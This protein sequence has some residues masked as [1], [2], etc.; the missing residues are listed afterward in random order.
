MNTVLTV[1]GVIVGA[2]VLCVFGLGA[3]AAVGH[4]I[5][6]FLKGIFQIGFEASKSCM[7]IL[8]L[9]LIILLLAFCGAKCNG[10]V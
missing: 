5:F 3:V 4:S 7:I 9:L 2:I 1:L 10:G 8:V 6:R